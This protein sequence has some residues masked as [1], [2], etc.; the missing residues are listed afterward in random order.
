[1]FLF[2]ARRRQENFS[3]LLVA[4]ALGHFGEVGVLVAGLAF[5]GEGGLEVLLGLGAGEGLGAG[6][7]RLFLDLF[8]NFRALVAERADV[9]GGELVAFVDVA[10]DFATVRH[11][12][13]S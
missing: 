6:G 2:V 1:M 3:E 13:F 11:F 12:L 4:F 7:G 10:A 5:A 9:V 8:E